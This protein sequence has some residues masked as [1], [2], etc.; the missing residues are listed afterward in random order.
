MQYI[1]AQ[2][3]QIKYFYGKMPTFSICVL[4]YLKKGDHTPFQ[5]MMLEVTFWETI[6]GYFHATILRVLVFFFFITVQGFLW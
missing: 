2:V 4:L 1:K 6:G 5:Q 3:A